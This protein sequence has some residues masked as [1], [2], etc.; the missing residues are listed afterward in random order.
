MK[1]HDPLYGSFVIPEFLLELIYTPEVR[2][3]SQIRLS[4][5]ISPS[6]ATL[7]ELRR[8][9]HTLGVLFLAL[10]NPLKGFT[11]I[12]KR[13]FYAS[14][15]LHDSGTAPFAHLFEYHLR[16]LK[17]WNHEFVAPGILRGEATP[18]NIAH[19]I[20]GFRAIDFKKR[21][22]K[23]NIPTDIVESILEKNHPLS[24]L[25]FGGLDIDNIDNVCRMS[26]SLGM[27]YPPENALNLAKSISI[28]KKFCI[29]LSQEDGTILVDEWAKNRKACY[30]NI[31]F[32]GPNMAAQ[33]V[34]FDSIGVA[35][36]NEILSEMDWDLTDEQL[37]AKLSGDSLTKENIIKWYLGNLPKLVFAIQVSGSLGDFNPYSIYELNKIVKVELN[38]IFPREKALGYVYIDAGTF[39]KELLFDDL[40]SDAKWKHGN[41]TESVILYGFIKS[42]K[43]ILDKH[44]LKVIDKIISKLNIDTHKIIRTIKGASGSKLYEQQEINF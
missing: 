1:I 29:N 13:S 24:L 40:Q 30:E 33:A 17:N 35:I 10:N 38:S 31:M 9:S 15:L 25:L 28:S 34:L 18:E 8:Y 44:C 6:L 41:K 21:L 39:E 22:S 12:E 26:W 42:S 7:G 3:L 2:R 36:K 20:Y 32:N 11:T 4:N 37:L 27:K 5:S 23:I 14:V 19:Q 43:K 16:E